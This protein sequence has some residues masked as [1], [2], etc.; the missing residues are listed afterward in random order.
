M[1]TCVDCGDHAAKYL[2]P[3]DYLKTYRSLCADCLEK[4]TGVRIKE[5]EIEIK[6]LKEISREATS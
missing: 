6:M 3:R 4:A 5:L 2:D 1:N